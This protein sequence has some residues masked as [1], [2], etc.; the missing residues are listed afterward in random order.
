M[1]DQPSTHPIEAMLAHERWVRALARSLVLDE[2]DSDDVVQQTWIAALRS[3][4]G[5]G[6]GLRGWLATVVRNAATTLRRDEDR[7]RSREQAA[8]RPETLP[9]TAEL[10]EE[11]HL[12]RHLVG[13]VL[14]L[15][16]PYRTTV[17]LRYFRE[18]R[19]QQIASLQGIPVATVKTRLHRAL[20]RLRKHFDDE[21]GG[22]RA[23]WCLPLIHLATTGVHAAATLGTAGAGLKLA[24]LGG[25]AVCAKL[26]LGLISTVLVALFAI[27][28]FGLREQE[29]DSVAGSEAVQPKSSDIADGVPDVV[30][31]AQREEV[32]KGVPGSGVGSD[33]VQV[34]ATLAVTT[35]YS[36][37]GLPAGYVNLAILWK[38][39][40]G[41]YGGDRGGRT[42]AEGRCVMTDLPP[43][44][45]VVATDM[46]TVD[47]AGLAI[48]NTTE[49]DIAIESGPDVVGLV[50]DPH[51]DAVPGA[52]IWLTEYGNW[53]KSHR[54]ATSA[55]DGQFSI[56]SAP[57]YCYVGARMAPWCPS[58]LHCIT[59]NPGETLVLTLQLGGAGGAI[60]GQVQDG[61][62]KPLVGVEVVLGKKAHEPVRFS[63]GSDGWKASVQRT[64]TAST[65]EFQFEGVPSGL[66][67]LSVKHRGFAPWSDV[68]S[69][70]AGQV[71]D[72]V[73]QLGMGA[74]VKGVV[75][76][77]G[78][79]ALAQVHFWSS[80]GESA[81]SSQLDGSFELRDLTPGRLELVADGPGKGKATVSFE[82]S[83]GDVLEWNPVLEPGCCLEGRVIDETGAVVSGHGV[84]AELV[85]INLSSPRGRVITDINGMFRITNCMEGAY[86]KV[87]VHDPLPGNPAPLAT[88]ESV[89]AGQSGIVIVCR[90]R[91]GWI[92]G[93]VVDADGSPVQ[94]A[95]VWAMFA[96]S[97]QPVPHSAPT[98]GQTGKFRVGPLPAGRVKATVEA[99]GRPAVETEW[100]DLGQGET[101]DVGT[102]R[103]AAGAIVIA[104]LHTADGRRVTEGDMWIKADG[105]WY[106]VLAADG[107]FRS[108]PVPPGAL[109]LNA[110]GTDFAFSSK[111]VRAGDGETLS[112]DMEVT[113]GTQCILRF[114]DRW[115]SRERAVVYVL[116]SDGEVI[117]KKP[118]LVHLGDGLADD[119]P[120]TAA[121]GDYRVLVFA[122]DRK[123]EVPFTH[124]EA[125]APIEIELK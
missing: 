27:V 91:R 71:V 14:R 109:T 72:V 39:D 63:D 103:M 122:G 15:D 18:M 110:S 54:V 123:H 124:T 100:H 26:K 32:Q 43:G 118:I 90:P 97:G 81:T 49:L 114:I 24:L 98:I 51:G 11:A 121:P 45:V 10:V 56:A 101:W 79:R 117:H 4:P 77:A 107:Q 57:R 116:N 108:V 22:D 41:S 7:R 47:H 5:A 93:S 69:I 83:P 111:E 119:I 36:P 52:E 25:L 61:D 44:E 28:W 35:R 65:G 88:V 62:R 16:E 64:E 1:S 6:R 19:A 40:D 48:G 85:D 58:D 2:A 29:V 31:Q 112:V 106:D 50:Q 104:T 87:L 82:A 73:I 3:P 23:A 67:T 33:Q 92:E 59:G 96:G 86:Y 75:R 120:L 80:R 105:R 89:R 99:R 78:G 94:S 53:F 70:V 74:T 84:R 95:S 66:R 21:Y 46:R 68:V 115:P 34:G 37:S 30:L 55:T 38:R 76:D 8:A 17:L 102:I 13:E 60:R 9:S 113:V 125:S 12:R 42:D 20:E